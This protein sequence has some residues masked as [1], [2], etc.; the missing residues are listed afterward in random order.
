MELQE[1]IADFAGRIEAGLNPYISYDEIQQWPPGHLDELMNMGILIETN[2]GKTVICKKCNKECSI[3]PSI[4]A[5][6]RTGEIVGLHLCTVQ[7]LIRVETKRLRRW[8]IVAERL[9]IAAPT[10]AE[11]EN[12]KPVEINL[13]D[14]S[15]TKS[16]QLM[17]DLMVCPS[18]VTYSKNNHGKDQP[19]AVKKI[20]K[21]KYPDVASDIHIDNE[22]IYLEKII[23][24]EKNNLP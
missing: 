1:Q 2:P 15:N 10:I 24:K 19:K 9:P 17:R 7:G 20:L 16:K 3:E 5:L 13:R 11:P 23:L 14:F 22:R 12:K 21:V 8:E 6:P 4:E 18:G